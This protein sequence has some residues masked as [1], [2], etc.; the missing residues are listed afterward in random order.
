YLPIEPAH[1]CVLCRPD[2]VDYIRPDLRR[3]VALSEEVQYALHHLVLGVDG[4]QDARPRQW[5]AG[6]EPLVEHLTATERAAGNVP[7]QAKELDTIAG[8]DGIS[9]QVLLDVRSQRT[10]E[11]RFARDDHEAAGS[12]E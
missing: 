11:V 10:R 8:T 3:V 5:I 12:E 6:E 1:G 4:V 7:G 9:G 2:V